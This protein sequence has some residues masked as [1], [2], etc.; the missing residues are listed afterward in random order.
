MEEYQALFEDTPSTLNIPVDIDV[1]ELEQS[2]NEQLKGLLYEDNDIRDGDKMMI[3]AEKKEPIRLSVDSNLI[4]YRV[5]LAL[6]IKY[7]LG[8]SKV[9]AEGDIALNLKT[10]FGLSPN[11][12]IT[13]KTEIEGYDWLRKPRLKMGGFNLPIGFIADLV[14]KNSKSV[15]TRNID[16]AV[17]DQFDLRTMVQDAW[18]QMYKPILVSED[19]NTWLTVNPQFIGMTPLVTQ[20]NHITATI[21]VEGKPHVRIGQQP[22]PIQPLPLPPLQMKASA[23]DDF[24]L[25]LNT[26]ITYEEAERLAK[27]QLLGETF[28]QGKR[29]V[30]IE[31]VELY[32]QGDKIVVNTVLRGSYNGSIYLVGKPVYNPQKNT[33]D[34]ESLEYTLDTR[35]FLVRS[36]GWL[37]KSTMKKKIEENM[38]FL[39]DYN[40]KEM[41]AQF[42][43][44]LHNYKLTEK[45]TLDGELRELGIENAYLSQESIIIALAL[46]GKLNILVKGLN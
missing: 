32:G 14:L 35:N 21:F 9:E 15:V 24:T 36:A 16:Q 38:N 39:L 26:E 18:K 37:L 46:K 20:G 8:I 4:Q 17:R 43:E 23:G 27:A 6:W 22:Q 30:L 7:D 25:H 12:D 33:I 29:S 3:R 13:T 31:D 19:Y 42:Q 10:A 41:Q 5:P 40:L 45:V 44:Q 1:R 34:V 11:W 28:S 2:I